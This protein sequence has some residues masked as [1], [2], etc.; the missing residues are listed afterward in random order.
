MIASAYREWL[1]TRGTEAVI[2][3][4]SNRKLQYDYDTAIY[5]QRNVIERMVAA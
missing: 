3:P 2:P 4:R 5:K 1:K